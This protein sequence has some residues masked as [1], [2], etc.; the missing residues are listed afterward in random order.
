MHYHH[1]Q[2][3][4][5]RS[6]PCR[7]T[8]L[9]VSG[10]VP[11]EVVKGLHRQ[12]VDPASLFAGLQ[13]AVGGVIADGYAA[14]QV[15]L[16]L[17]VGGWAGGQVRTQHAAYRHPEARVGRLGR[18]VGRLVRRGRFHSCV[19]WI[20]FPLAR[21]ACAAVGTW[22]FKT[23]CG[24]QTAKTRLL[25]SRYPLSSFVCCTP[26]APKADLLASPPPSHFAPLYSLP[27]TNLQRP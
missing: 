8:I 9:D 20:W 1:H 21:C 27:L 2:P 14:Q 3:A 22:M 26:R 18:S 25:F 16:Q 13:K 15:L 6:S 11:P 24:T 5:A 12:L 17:Q 7:A 10:Q 23:L 4:H 19:S